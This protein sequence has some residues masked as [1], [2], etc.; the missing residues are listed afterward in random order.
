[1]AKGGRKPQWLPVTHNASVASAETQLNS[2]GPGR[3]RSPLNGL[4]NNVTVKFP[5]L[6]QLKAGL[7][8]GSITQS[9]FTS[10]ALYSVA[11]ASRFTFA[12][13]KTRPPP[14]RVET[15]SLRLGS[16]RSAQIVSRM[17]QQRRADLMEPAE[18]SVLLQSRHLSKSRP[19]KRDTS[20][21]AL[22]RAS[23]NRVE[24]RNRSAA[25]GHLRPG[26][27]QSDRAV[28]HELVRG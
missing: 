15:A 14:M 26:I 16:E 13:I 18:L 24:E 28:E 25:R 9:Q 3:E 2:A 7:A 27:A 19:A 4:P 6:A 22:A 5:S 8:N 12:E 17:L 10:L 1:M 21:A 20:Q 11:A 23:A